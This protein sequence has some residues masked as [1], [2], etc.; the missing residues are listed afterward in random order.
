MKTKLQIL[1]LVCLLVTSFHSL[2]KCQNGIYLTASDFINNKLSYEKDDKIRL[3]NSAWEMPYITVFENGNKLK[4]RKNEIFGYSDRNNNV[5]RFYKNAA[6][7]I[8]EA[9]NIIIYMQVEKIAQSKGFMVKKNYY[10]STAAGSEIIALT[11]DNLKSAYHGNEKFIDLLDKYFN[12]ADVSAYDKM[13]SIYKV[14][15]VYTKSMK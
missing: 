15:Y 14:N 2:A 1:S 9:G 8:A 13:H 7:Q 10:F 5:Y 12:D 4:I 3:N 6:Y 11:I